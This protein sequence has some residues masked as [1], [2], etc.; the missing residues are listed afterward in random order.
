MKPDGKDGGVDLT[1]VSKDESAIMYG[2]SK[3]TISKVEEVDT[4]MSKFKDYYERI[5]T[6]KALQMFAFPELSTPPQ[7]NR[8]RSKKPK[9]PRVNIEI[10]QNTPEDVIFVIVTLS[11][12]KVRILPE[13][14]KS[15]MASKGFY[16]TLKSEGK[17]IILDGPEVLP[18]AQSAYRKLY[19]IPSNVDINFVNGFVNHDNVYIG[20]ISAKE[21]GCVR[22]ECW[23]WR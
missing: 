6:N 15:K 20:V 3:L 23:G 11:K 10:E 5:H 4:I 13:Y 8:M 19:I 12:I 21:L 16:D 22:T 7:R 1:A 2:Q 14:E 9:Q 17:L 18:L